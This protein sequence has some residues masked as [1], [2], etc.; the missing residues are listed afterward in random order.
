LKYIL[1]ENKKYSKIGL[2]TGRFGTVVPEELSFE[3]LDYFYEH[4]GT[5]V[6]TAR[7]YYEWIDNGRGKSEECIGRWLESRNNR[8]RVCI[9]TKGGV[10]NYGKEWEI[11]LSR[12][13]LLEELKQSLD[14]LKTDYLDIYLLHRDEP[15]RSVEEI[16]ETMQYLKEYGNIRNI[17][18]SNWST[19]RVIKANEYARKNNLEMFRIV[20]TWWSLAEYKY[21][22]WNDDNTTHMEQSMYDY[23]L[24][25]NMVGMA[26]TSQCKGF[27]Q[28]AIT[29]GL[30]SID[31][32]L[33][34]RIVTERNLNKLNYIKDYCDKHSVSPTAV[35]NS[36]IT[37]NQLEGIALV[38]TSKIE[39]L[40]DVFD[41]CDYKLEHFII[42]EIDEI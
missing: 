30:D 42:D 16:V 7:N 19:E 36:Y 38:S 33:K 11:N 12:E 10:K 14:A 21:E 18:V 4:G 8:E 35:V 20:Q 34:H 6:D 23:M 32:F 17:G 5:V 40:V 39:Q 37:S 3:L 27:F 29:N 41:C 13:R 25:N 22:M 9:S 2:G 26:Y 24:E 1:S 31:E 15:L 28:K